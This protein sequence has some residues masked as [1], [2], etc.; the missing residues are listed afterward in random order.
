MKRIVIGAAALLAAIAVALGVRGEL[1][2]DT[3]NGPAGA[4]AAVESPA[5]SRAEAGRGS[6]AVEG[7]SAADDTSVEVAADAPAAG[8]SGDARP[9]RPAPPSDVEPPVGAPPAGE[10]AA[11]AP[12]AAG[13]EPGSAPG[14]ASARTAASG[15]AE[16]AGSG[17]APQQD[18]ATVLRGASSAY[19]AI[20]SLRAE[21]VQEVENPIL[22][23]RTVSRGTLYQ[24]QPDRLLMRFSDPAGDVVVSDGRYIWAYYPSVDEK[25][26]MRVAAARGAP[27]GFDLRAQFI[28]DPLQ[29]FAAR[30]EGTDTVAGR[31]AHVLHLTPRER[32]T[33]RSLKVWVDA[34]D[35]LVR[36]FVIEEQNGVTREFVLSG[37]ELNPTLADSLFEFTPP[38]GTQV[39]DRG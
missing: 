1:A 33:Y 22:G 25:Q 2:P 32:T 18:A 29:R 4:V 35:H 23:S 7:A 24:R 20:R 21:F 8:A 11:G 16:Q 14:T 5:A 9:A 36:R 10:R 30:L 27:S 39:I 34:R 17:G 13:A 12:V 37:L 38:P 3:P 28:G 19:E 6:D 15:A 31:P 26:V